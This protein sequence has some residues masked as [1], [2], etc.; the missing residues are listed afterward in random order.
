MQ[1]EL[2]MIVFAI[3]RS[4]FRG[5]VVLSLR[6]SPFRGYFVPTPHFSPFRGYF[7]LAQ[8]ISLAAYAFEMSI[9][10]SVSKADVVAA[11]TWLKSG[12]GDY[13]GRECSRALQMQE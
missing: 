9:L 11:L 6:C 13:L 7:I 12:H 1:S 8:G 10:A 3:P 2:R 4:P 5:Y